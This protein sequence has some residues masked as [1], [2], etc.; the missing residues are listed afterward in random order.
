MRNISNRNMPA[1]VLAKAAIS[2]PGE[3]S[4]DL[5]ACENI[6][7]KGRH[8]DSPATVYNANPALDCKRHRFAKSLFIMNSHAF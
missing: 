4:A 7:V 8:Y 3:I 2:R 5:R 6:G 1:R